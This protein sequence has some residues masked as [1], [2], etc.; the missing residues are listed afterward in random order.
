[1]RSQLVF[2]ALSALT[3][4]SAQNFTIDPNE[5]DLTTRASWCSGEF[6]TCDTLCDNDASEN[7]CEPSTLVYSCI[8]ASN[9]SAPGLEYYSQSLPSFICQQAFSD[10]N[11]ANAGNAA[12]QRNCTTTI[13]DKCGTLDIA[14]Y[15]ATPS[16]TSAAASSS[17]TGQTSST[18]SASGTGASAAATSS[19]T[20]AA[21]PTNIH[22]I[23]NGAA[24]MAV[25]VFAYLL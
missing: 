11:L 14:N 13:K 23:G 1:M 18:A 15:T 24:A 8:C 12:G 10:C 7:R 22:L 17:A 4:V 20:A 2:L 6:S 9:G 5:V 21:A 16:T 3:A 25:G 19:S